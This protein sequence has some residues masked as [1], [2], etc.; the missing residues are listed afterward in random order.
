MAV[1]S[2]RTPQEGLDQV[3]K[4]LDLMALVHEIAHNPD[5]GSTIEELSQ[6]LAKAQ[7]LSDS[8][9]QELLDAQEIITQSKEFI[10]DFEKSKKLHIANVKSE[11]ED[12][13]NKREALRSDIKS[14][15]D[16]KVVFQKSIDSIKKEV[17]DKLVQVK[18]LSDDSKNRLVEAKKSE[19]SVA[20]AKQEHETIVAEFEK[21]QEIEANKLTAAHALHEANVKKLAEDRAAF[22]LRKNK[23]E[24]LLRE[25]E[26]NNA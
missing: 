17:A 2:F 23:F 26:L 7:E 9:K 20:L 3:S 14:F 18:Q 4:A 1:I 6:K 22:V 16:E 25:Q 21:N 10:E 19:D 13:G 24:D 12:I 8:K 5:I 11:L 15:A